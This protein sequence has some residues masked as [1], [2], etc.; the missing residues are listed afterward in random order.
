MFPC[1]SEA[2]GIASEPLSESVSS[3]VFAYVD[4][5]DEPMTEDDA[6]VLRAGMDKF[7]ILQPKTM[8]ERLQR[9]FARIG[10]AARL[11]AT[12]A[13]QSLGGFPRPSIFSNTA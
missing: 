5:G 13:A 2:V 4:L 1:A 8:K 10:Q 12:N 3:Q 6:A 11:A 9:R 7:E